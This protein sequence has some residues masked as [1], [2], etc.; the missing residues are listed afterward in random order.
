MWILCQETRVLILVYHYK[1]EQPLL[2]YYTSRSLFLYLHMIN[3]IKYIFT[4]R[5]YYYFTVKRQ[6]K[7]KTTF[8]SHSSCI[9]LS[10]RRI[11]LI[12]QKFTLNIFIL[13]S[14][15][16]ILIS[17]YCFETGYLDFLRKNIF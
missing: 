12:L 7:L 17:V 6:N 5:F 2:S 13:N 11:I 16:K 9:V 1:G 3:N 8:I 4:L 10:E 14:K 15:S